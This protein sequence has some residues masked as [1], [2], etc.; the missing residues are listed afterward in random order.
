MKLLASRYLKFLEE[1]LSKSSTPLG[2]DRVRF[3]SSITGKDIDGLRLSEPEYWVSNL[4]QPVRFNQA[5]STIVKDQPENICLEVGPHSTLAGPLRQICAESKTTCNYVPTM[6][7]SQNCV[8]C[9]LS[10][11]GQLY[12]QALSV[13]FATLIPIGKTLTD[14]PNYPWDHS[15]SFWNETRLSHD[16]RFREVGHHALLGQRIPES[17]SLAP[18]W[19]VL[20][21]LED[22]PWLADHKVKDD[23]VF[24]F[25]GYVSMAGEAIRQIS[26]SE[27]GYSTRHVIAHTALV[28]TDTKPTEMV[29][30]LSR[31]KLTDSSDSDAYSFV[32]QS[33]AGPSWIKNCEG[34]VKPI[35]GVIP[36]SS[37]IT[38]QPR[39][40][41]PSN[42]YEI[43]ARVG[44]VYGPEFQGITS[45]SASTTERRATAEIT[46]TPGRHNP[47]PLHP[48]T[49]DS[50]LQVAI[51]AMAQGTSRNF[52]QLAV[53]TLIQELD[54]FHGGSNL[55]VT[56]WTAADGME[57]CIDCTNE[58]RPA[59]RLRGGHL[60]PLDDEK[61]AV[62]Y[63]RHA[64]ARLEW[65][66]D[67][68][69]MDNGPLLIPPAASI[70]TK[71]LLEELTLACLLDSAERLDALGTCI[72]H[73][74]KFRSWLRREVSRAKSGNYPIVEDA[75]GY[76]K[77]SRQARRQLIQDRMAR[78]SS[79]DSTELVAK[80]ILRI[81]ENAEGLFTGTVD[82][83]ELLMRDDVLTEIYNVVS[84]GF[85][86]FVRMLSVTKPNLRVLEVG[87]G[88]GGTTELI[89]RGL[90]SSGGN[91]A[92]STYTYTDI[93]AGFFPQAKERFAYAVNMEYRL[94]DISQD[95]LSQGFEAQSYDLILA[96]NVIHATPSLQESLRNLQPL[97]HPHGHLVLSEMCADARAPGYVFGNFSGWW[98]GESDNRLWEPYVHP[99]RWDKEL[100]DA[101]FS[102]V[103]T[104]VYD[105]E[106]P[107]QY[108]AAIVTQP[109]QDAFLLEGRPLTIL[110]SEASEGISQVLVKD[111]RRMG[112]QITTAKFGDLLPTDQDV[113]STMDLEGP[114]FDKI[115]ESQFSH[116]Q[117]M[118]K[119]YGKQNFLWLMPPTQ[120]RCKNP[121]AAQTIGLLRVLRAE[122]ALPF[123][124]LE[125]APSETE[126][127]RLVMQVYHKIVTYVDTE[128]IAPDREFAVDDGAIKIG[129][130]QP[131][132]L[133]Q[134]LNDKTP[135]DLGLVKVLEIAKPGLLETLHWIQETPQGELPS[136]Q[137][138]IMTRAV[139]LNFRVS[140]SNFD[141][142]FGLIEADM[143]RTS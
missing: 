63:D 103:D 112:M 100:K 114:F 72:P 65:Y 83:L 90:V 26:G 54:V 41:V 128:R 23:I 136:N 87:A 93:S 117:A 62:D 37:T 77:M 98:L 126:F 12:Q 113:I 5:V 6:L 16:W 2:K 42:W 18:S 64:A 24:P 4:I 122:L 1:E 110:C 58:G 125:I 19:R 138:E 73:F 70:D 69:F 52:T 20:L 85:G 57:M 14:L 29:T 115:T 137:V 66:H 43:M 9:L 95:P 129:R 67:F 140:F 142:N 25:A 59:L 22:E 139:G 75:A 104:V 3:V 7:R 91:P 31:L 30:T 33:H 60:T 94:F 108:C 134:E 11:F 92:Y 141:Q 8:E 131:F 123:A 32:I 79:G 38:P 82:T 81:C 40:V 132:S 35:S 135:A 121:H 111:L 71:R 45:L 89:L 88:T 53:P 116:L 56:A 120:I 61:P 84:F 86:G 101:G 47:F 124:S 44:L 15:V 27:E 109:K 10:A 46:T 21:E 74:V 119:N 34:L 118:L 102:G 76:V 39:K 107:Y 78:L 13:D 49:I 48:A 96:P 55:N 99:D 50:C 17:T 68:D 127:S 36:L 97:L 28:L 143:T 106:D 51:A 133:E 80:G 130:Y 105:A